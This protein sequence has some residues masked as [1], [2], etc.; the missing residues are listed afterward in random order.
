MASAF[1]STCLTAVESGSHTSTDVCRLLTQGLRNWSTEPLTTMGSQLTSCPLPQPIPS[2]TVKKPPLPPRILE[3]ILSTSSCRCDLLE[4]SGI[5]RDNP[6]SLGCHGWHVI[7][8]APN[9]F[10]II[11]G[12]GQL[13]GKLCCLIHLK[14][15]SA[16]AQ[17]PVRS[18][19]A[20]RVFAALEMNPEVWVR[21]SPGTQK[22]K[23]WRLLVETKQLERM[24][25][26][27]F[28]IHILSQPQL[29]RGI[30]NRH[31][32]NCPY[33]YSLNHLAFHANL[34]FLP[35]LPLKSKA[36]FPLWRPE[37]N[38]D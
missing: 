24:K 33:E 16:K 15:N 9:N 13:S 18:F 35:W 4:P 17:V 14:F 11:G 25:V 3:L 8:T 22:A 2:L 27:G 37:F 28:S 21:S 19:R 20:L 7:H 29:E 31:W 32:L 10:V 1:S 23:C 36:S 30:M 6:G 38:A 26:N 34:F 12:K 5:P